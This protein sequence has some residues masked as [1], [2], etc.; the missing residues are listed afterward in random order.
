MFSNFEE[1]RSCSLQVVIAMVDDN[2]WWWTTRLT[3]ASCPVSAKP[4][5]AL[6]CTQTSGTRR[7]RRR[8]TNIISMWICRSDIEQSRTDKC[9]VLS[10]TNAQCVSNRVSIL[11]RDCHRRGTWPCILSFLYVHS[12]YRR[13]PSILSS[14]IS[15]WCMKFN[16]HWLIAQSRFVAWIAVWR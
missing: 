14:E 16:V 15:C 5:Q 11:C 2:F 8:N 7:L 6:H 13:C 4:L 12:K 10:Q 9:S 1:F 3:V